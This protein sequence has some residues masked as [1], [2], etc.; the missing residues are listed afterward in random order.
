MNKADYYNLLVQTSAEGRFPSI[1]IDGLNSSCM[2]RSPEG[3]RCAV[4]LIIPDEKYKKE[5]EQTNVLSLVDRFGLMLDL[6]EG[7]TLTDLSAIQKTHDSMALQW[8]EKSDSYSAKPWDHAH[9][10]RQLNELQ[11]FS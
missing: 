10:V 3:L 6:P 2:Y 1:K 5:Y 11:C 9:F 4:G 8:D 7:L